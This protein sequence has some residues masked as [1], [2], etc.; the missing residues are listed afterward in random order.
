MATVG[1]DTDNIWHSR[2]FSFWGD[3][4]TVQNW[5]SDTT[6]DQVR[7]GSPYFWLEALTRRMRLSKLYG[8]GVSGDGT[9][10]LLR[11]LV[12][13]VP[14]SKGIRPAD[15][16][17]SYAF[18]L[19]G[20][21]DVSGSLAVA[22]FIIN[23]E[24]ILEWFLRRGHIPIIIAE[25]PRGDSDSGTLTTAGQ[26]KMLAWCD[27]LRGLNSR[28]N[29]FVAD[30][31]VY[32]MDKAR[33]DL[34]PLEGILQDDGLHNNPPMG[35]ATALSL[36]SIIVNE[37]RLPYIELSPSCNGDQYN[38][39]SFLRGCI[40]TNPMLVQGAG[41]I[42]GANASGLAP[43]GYTLETTNAGLL[44]AGSFT[45][46]VFEGRTTP[47]FRMT[48][49][50]TPSIDSAVARLVQTGLKS[51]MP[52]GISYFGGM[53]AVIAE[54]HT[55]L[56][57]PTVN[58]DTGNT[59]TQIIA[60]VMMTTFRPFPS[61]F[62]PK[63]DI[64]PLTPDNILAD[65]VTSVSAKFEICAGKPGVAASIVVDFISAFVRRT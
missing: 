23:Y 27:Y 24:V 60:G 21:N 40:N 8:F 58:L 28:E 45:T 18:I 46:T 30:P 3:S 11:R 29:I 38:S 36:N 57:G 50:G 25:W 10:Q 52:V 48:I 34:R 63:L 26:L 51:K 47:C 14:N 9:Y 15:V 54:N 49:S 6:T 17:P 59:D 35:V 31:W 37:L 56:Y 65:D 64:R 1:Y 2:P 42:L 55:N 53:E 19:L 41:G 4:R 44:V 13:N 5:V 22:N 20:T 16:P 61:G 43:E 33:T 39:T 62:A 12:D 7:C 32:V